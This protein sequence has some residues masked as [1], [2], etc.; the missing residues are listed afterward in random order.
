MLVVS[1]DWPKLWAQ[2]HSLKVRPRSA[3]KP[4]RVGADRGH[5]FEL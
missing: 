3:G 4:A 5:L 2:G 1:G